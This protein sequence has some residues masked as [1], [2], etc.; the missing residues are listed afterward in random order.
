MRRNGSCARF[1]GNAGFLSGSIDQEVRCIIGSCIVTDVF[2]SGTS[3][4]AVCS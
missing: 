3:V 2:V 1:H 4:N